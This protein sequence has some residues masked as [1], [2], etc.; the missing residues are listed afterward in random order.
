ML[1]TRVVPGGSEVNPF[2]A[3]ALTSVQTSL[4]VTDE[5]RLDLGQPMGAAPQGR[6]GEAGA[7]KARTR[8]LSSS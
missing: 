1:I 8:P 7:I 3:A 2:D 6:L 5:E 4:G